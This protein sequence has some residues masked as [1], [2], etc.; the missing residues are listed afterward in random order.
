[1]R[2]QIAS[3]EEGKKILDAWLET[4]FKAP[5]PASDGRP[6]NDDIQQFLDASIQEMER[7]SQPAQGNNVPSV[8]E[9]GVDDKSISI[10]EVAHAEKT[11]DTTMSHMDLLQKLLESSRVSV[12]SPLNEDTAG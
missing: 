2:A 11:S 3:S 8:E 9:G 6:W 12:K 5:C 7:I 1:M 4:P 10:P